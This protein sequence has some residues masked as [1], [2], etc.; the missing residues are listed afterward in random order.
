MDEEEKLTKFQEFLVDEFFKY[1]NRKHR[2]RVSET[3]FAKFLGVKVA[4]YNAWINGVRLP[5][6]ANAV[7][8]ASRLGPQVFDILGM[9]RVSVSRDPQTMYILD[10]WSEL[11]AE[12]KTE[13]LEHIAE[14]VEKFERGAGARIRD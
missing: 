6:Y 8:L 7:K 14:E 9:E 3:E 12:T 10:H 11:D 1:Q 4:S 13:I 5:D 2:R